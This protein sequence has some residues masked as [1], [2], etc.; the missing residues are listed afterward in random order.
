MKIF[1]IAGEASGDIHGYN[2]AKELMKLIPD[3]SLYGTGGEKLKSL[4]QKQLFTD[5]DM[6]II[7]F[8]G[9]IKKLPFILKMFKETEKAVRKEKPDAVILVDYPGFNLRM[10]KRL[11]KYGMPIIYFIAPQFWVWNYRRIYTLR[12]YCDLTISI[13]PFETEALKKEGV[14]SVY[15][16]NP[17]IDNFRFRFNDK[18]E[19]LSAAGLSSD[20]PVIGV[21]PGSRLKE[22]SSLMPV[23]AAASQRYKGQFQFVVSRAD[24]IPDDYMREYSGGLSFLSGAQYDIMKYSDFIWACSG[25]VTLETAIMGKPMIIAYTSSWFNLFLAKR[26]SKLRTVGLPNIMSGYE[27]LPE[28]LGVKITPED[29]VR[30]TEKALSN[31]DRIKNE[32]GKISSQFIG[33]TP[34]RTAAAEIYSLLKERGKIA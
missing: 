6:A 2:L 23:F 33:M 5:K 22:V 29:I 9:V 15:A 31:I 32:L 30:C 19:F 28:A 13:Y 12:D 10:A 17:V 26:L 11:K 14:A 21:L 27:F 18:N 20:L 34:S 7:G 16:G 8:D 25:T 4:G 24:S 1:I 3:I